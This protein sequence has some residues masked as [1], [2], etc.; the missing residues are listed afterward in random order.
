MAKKKKKPRPKGLLSEEQ[1]EAMRE[2]EDKNPDIQAAKARDAAKR[3]RPRK[4]KPPK[5]KGLLD[6]DD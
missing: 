2:R 4:K 5:H 3:K 1:L 6:K